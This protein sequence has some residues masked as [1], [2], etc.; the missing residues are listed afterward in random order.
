MSQEPD[1]S[2]DL[3]GLEMDLL[4]SLQP[5]WVK[6][7]PQVQKFS[8]E[9]GHG[10][11]DHR[12]GGRFDADEGDFGQRG[13]RRM[14]KFKRPARKPAE[15]FGKERPRHPGK[16][17]GGFGG[18]RQHGGGGFAPR[19]PEPREK[20]LEGW[21]IQFVPEERGVEGLVKQIKA[22]AKAYALF[23]LGR[24]VLEKSPR[25]RV[26]FKRAAGPDLFLCVADSTLWLSESDA[27]NHAISIC[28]ETHYRRERVAVEPPKGDFPAVAQC[29]M[30]G[31]FLGPPNHH[32]YQLKLRK[33]HAERF[34]NVPFDVFKSR[35]KTVRDEESLA[36]WKEEQSFA[37]VYHPAD[38]PEG[39]E[40]QPLRSLAEVAEHFRK[41]H[42]AS[43]VAPA[44]DAF[45]VPGPAAVNDSAR[46]VVSFVRR[47]LDNLIRFPLPMAHAL[48]RQLGASGLQ[49]FKANEN[50][51][52]VSVARPKPIDRQ[53]VPVSPSAG[54][55]LDYLEANAA[56]PRAKQW[57]DLLALPLP[58][59]GG[60]PAQREQALLR[61]LYWLLH[62]GHVV[63][64]ATKNL[65]AAK[66]PAPRK[67]P[68]AKPEAPKAAEGGEGAAP[69][70]AVEER[71]LDS[72]APDEAVPAGEV[73]TVPEPAAEAQ[74]PSES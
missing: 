68:K 47:D 45:E 51:T 44:G 63:D 33:L 50:I 8:H 66:R 1:P 62:Q 48:G 25:Y 3:S 53:T 27:L 37:D 55:I 67:P 24:L 6:D 38:A 20:F 19:F 56:T 39:A 52:Y 12:S 57:Q 29:G 15:G 5:S 23:D 74:A 2:A 7:G 26:S 18:P 69:A 49:I 71:G 21:E 36:K 42:A 40:P 11:G 54:A 14:P 32:D 61:D 43:A 58:E 65:Q 16:S 9:A 34:S 64:F 60:E 10:G 72:C 46:E 41:N 70:A 31:V 73:E 13:E 59:A 22:H 35:V 30:S 28:S 4:R 17:G